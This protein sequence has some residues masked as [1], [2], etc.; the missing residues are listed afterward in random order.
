MRLL[1]AT[2]FPTWPPRSGAAL[3]NFHLYRHVAQ[4]HPVR[5]LALVPPAKGRIDAEIAPGL[6]EERIPFSQAHADAEAHGAKRVPETPTWDISCA[7]LYPL[8]PEYL[9]ALRREAEH[10]DIVVASHPHLFYALREV[11]SKPLVYE[12]PDVEVDLKRTMLPV[13]FPAAEFLRAAQ[14]AEADCC[15]EAAAVVACTEEDRVRLQALYGV[16]KSRA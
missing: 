16:E 6:H 1:V 11:T 8:T 9:E 3:R 12:A 2:T 14:R 15:R 13:H 5:L 4:R 10:A 7:W